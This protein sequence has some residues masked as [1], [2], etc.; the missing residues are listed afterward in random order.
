MYRCIVLD[1]DG[2]L[3]DE[4]GVIHHEVV[5]ALEELLSLIHI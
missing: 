1:V 4:R 2:T 5:E 3:T